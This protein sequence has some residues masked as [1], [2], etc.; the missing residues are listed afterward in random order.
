VDL[1]KL[2][3]QPWRLVAA[4]S[5]VLDGISM[6][7]AGL[8]GVLGNRSLLATI[9]L[10]SGVSSQDCEVESGRGS[11]TGLSSSSTEGVNLGASGNVSVF[12]A[13]LTRF[14]GMGDGVLSALTCAASVVASDADACVDVEISARGDDGVCAAFSSSS[15]SV[16]MSSRPRLPTSFRMLL[17]PPSTFSTGVVS[18][19]AVFSASLRS[20]RAVDSRKSANGPRWASKPVKMSERGRAVEEGISGATVGGVGCVAVSV[21]VFSGSDCNWIVS[22]IGF[23]VASAFAAVPETLVTELPFFSGSITLDDVVGGET[24][25]KLSFLRVLLL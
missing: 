13:K 23:V 24:E 25:L 7:T 5:F 16:V 4:S 17:K 3:M 18:A 21:T 6:A 10:R 9:A 11:I 19:S 8:T 20:P 22:T 2:S 12:S 15:C 14:S 1:K